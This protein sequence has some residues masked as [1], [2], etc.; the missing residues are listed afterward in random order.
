MKPGEYLCLCYHELVA[1]MNAC[2]VGEMALFKTRYITWL[3]SRVTNIY[4]Q[5]NK[6]GTP[7]SNQ[8]HSLLFY[9]RS[10]S[11]ESTSW[12]WR[13]G[14]E[15][16]KPSEEHTRRVRMDVGP[17]IKLTGGPRCLNESFT[18]KV[19]KVHIVIQLL[20]SYQ[21]K[22][23]NMDFP[24]GPV[25]KNLPCNARDTGSIPGPGRSLMLLSNKA[26]LPQLMSLS[27]RALES[28][29]LSPWATT[30]EAHT[31]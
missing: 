20:M 26:R 22:R 4:M 27:P 11:T 19:Y 12:L 18:F 30:T 31:L 6:Q 29:L 8:T 2:I 10:F 7:K 3:L 23:R 9:F 5:R 28:Q 15:P 1:D 25:V 13:L 14:C 24:G 16:G 17:T 21:I